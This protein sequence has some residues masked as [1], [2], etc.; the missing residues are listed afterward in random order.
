MNINWKQ[1]PRLNF[2]NLALNEAFRI[3]GAQA[4]Y[5]KVDTTIFLKEEFQRDYVGGKFAMYELATGRL[6]KP[7]PSDIEPIQVDISVSVPSPP[8]YKKDEYVSSA[9]M[10][11][12]NEKA[13]SP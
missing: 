6:F 12:R 2:A 13:I 11:S 4:I 5:V 1:Q 7:T 10:I 3:I 8:I 9:D